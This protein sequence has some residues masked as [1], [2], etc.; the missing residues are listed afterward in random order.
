METYLGSGTK[1]KA[2]VDRRVGCLAQPK[3]LNI[4]GWKP[5]PDPGSL[6]GSIDKISE[7]GPEHGGR[8][9][10]VGDVVL[11]MSRDAAAGKTGGTES[12]PTWLH[13]GLIDPDWLG[14]HINILYTRL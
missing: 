4:V 13:P 11:S 12:R 7:H 8:D 9:G 14:G 2:R 3:I 10:D 5:D 1:L 6:R